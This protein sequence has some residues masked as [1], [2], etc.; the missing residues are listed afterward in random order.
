VLVNAVVAAEDREFFTHSGVDPWG[1]GRALWHDLRGDGSL[2]GGS[3]ITQQYVKN[4]YL[5]HERT[6]VRKLREAVLA[7]KLER[8]LTKEQ[9]L[10]RYL[11]AIY[12]GRG[13]Y[14][15]AAASRAYFGHD[16]GDLKLHEAAYLA[17]LIRSPETADASYPEFRDEARF[18]IRSVLD[19]MVA[20]RMISPGQ[21][22]EAEAV[23]FE[24][25][26]IG[27]QDRSSSGQ[28]VR[29]DHC[30][31]AY[32]VDYVRQAL[33]ADPRFGAGLYT[34]GLRIYTTIDP[35]QQCAAYDQLY[36]DTLTDGSGPSGALVSID[37][38][39]HV[40]AMVGGRDYG[41]SQVNLAVG[42][43]GG[44]SGRQPG[45]AFK[46]FALAAA[47]QAG[48]SPMSRFPAPAKLTV[49]GADDGKD[50]VV[51]NYADAGGASSL[52][53]LDATKESSNTV[54]A[55]LMT[56]VGADKV[57][58]MAHRLGVTADL[59]A[60]PA[61]VLGTAEVS[62]LDMASAYSTFANRGWHTDPQVVVRVDD[63][64][65][66]PLWQPQSPSH[67]VLPE[68]QA[69]EITSALR[70]VI[71]DGTGTR[72]RIRLDAAGKTGTTED[73]RDAWFV[74]YT[75]NLTTAVWMGYSGEAGQAVQPM[76]GILGVKEVTGGTLPARMW[77][78]YMDAVTDGVGECD[79]TPTPVT[80]T[81]KVLGR[82]LPSAS[83]TS[84]D[85]SSPSST[86]TSS[87]SSSS[88]PSTSTSSAP[89]SAPDSS[90]VPSPSP[91]PSPSG[92]GST[93]ST[94]TAA[95]ST[96][97]STSGSSESPSAGGAFGAP[98]ATGSG[99]PSG[100]GAGGTS[101]LS[102][103]ATRAAPAAT[104]AGPVAAST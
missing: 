85:S 43:A 26:V 94:P 28:W 31:S 56:T 40:V 69:D 51:N 3:T 6:V 68:Q 5:T 83:S 75:C 71:D 97:P 63:A 73:A 58:D 54:Y 18:R 72:A 78:S 1:V 10:E 34:R 79:L 36:Q 33:L 99:G 15:V 49:P 13:A 77:S 23:P 62:V 65:G 64:D 20:E 87:P 22:A 101:V 27:R 37:Q 32:F 74:G 45:S 41:T 92:P 7:V 89:T 93:S 76:K 86:V 80:W 81:G 19:A 46:P 59:P 39:G 14:G 29:D 55:Q 70:G 88:T 100:T 96:S 12:F 4:A 48:I 60:V 98:D 17:G 11:N 61:L 47:V 35:R 52:T 53:L 57:V 104:G 95:A 38:Q 84:D 8:Q 50:W 91:A 24:Q 66:H 102:G 30:G 103:Q 16:L 21:A 82:D 9:I 42:R 67:Q 44:G 90:P 25:Y 2:Q